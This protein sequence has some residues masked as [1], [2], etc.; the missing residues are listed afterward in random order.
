MTDPLT[1]YVRVKVVCVFSHAGRILA[2]D[3]YDPT[4]DQ[5]FWVPVGGR[6]ELGEKSGAALIREV[7]EELAT[8]VTDLS[9]LGVLENIFTFDGGNGHE[10]VFVY[11]GRLANVSMYE[12]AE[13]I[14]VE[15][16]GQQ[17]SAYWIDPTAPDNGWPLYPDGLSDLLTPRP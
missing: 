2:I 14:G 10:I 6:V 8:D 9:L 12:R 4:K 1:G 11:D 3:G 7:R 13:V 15:D 16:G 5:R 17:F